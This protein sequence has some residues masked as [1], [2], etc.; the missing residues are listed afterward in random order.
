[1]NS[2]IDAVYVPQMLENGFVEKAGRG[3]EGA[4]IFTPKKCLGFGSCLVRPVGRGLAVSAADFSLRE[5]I[6]LVWKQPEFFLFGFQWG[7]QAGVVGHIGKNDIYR[8]RFPAGFY[9]QGVSVCF[10]PAFFDAFLVERHGIPVNVLTGALDALNRCAP[11]ADAAVILR[12]IG[13][14]ALSADTGNARLEAKALEL[15]TVVLDWHRRLGSQESP[16]PAALDRAGISKALRH[17]DEHFPEAISLEM[18]AKTAMM[19]V[20]KFTS[21]F[22]QQTGLP[23][24][25]FINRL[26]MEKALDLLKNTRISIGEIT[27]MV[28]YKH[29]ASFSAAFQEQFGFA[30]SLLRRL[31]T[32][33]PS[34]PDLK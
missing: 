7:T 15:I 10:L 8:G 12:Q 3:E 9:N 30:P 18:L 13:E 24:G 32:S 29:H 6:E 1:M 26:R 23:A 16:P 27:I 31:R 28:G 22:R 33:V 21:C 25:A 5:S 17:I 34:V 14:A 19:S 20:S 2:I 11:P 4:L